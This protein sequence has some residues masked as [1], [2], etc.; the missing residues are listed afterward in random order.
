MVVII[1]L[2]ADFVATVKNRNAALSQ[3]KSMKHDIQ[4]D[5]MLKFPAISLIFCRLYAAKRSRRTAKT[6]IAETRIVIVEF[7]AGI[8]SPVISLQIVVKIFL[9]FNLVNS[10]LCE[11]IIIQPPADIVVAAEIIQESILFRK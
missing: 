6:R 7:S 8:A 3:Q 4:P 9:V 10:E 2:L 5:G 11:E 1:I